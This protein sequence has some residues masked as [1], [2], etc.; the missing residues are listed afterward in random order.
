[1]MIIDQQDN[2]ASFNG[3]AT[4]D[5]EFSLGTGTQHLIKFKAESILEQARN[6]FKQKRDFSRYQ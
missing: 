1:M 2:L 3:D 4:L 5:S 6:D